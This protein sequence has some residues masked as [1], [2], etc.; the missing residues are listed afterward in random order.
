MKRRKREQEIASVVFNTD[1]YSVSRSRSNGIH[2]SFWLSLWIGDNSQTGIA[3]GPENRVKPW[4]KGKNGGE[5]QNERHTKYFSIMFQGSIKL[6][7]YSIWRWDTVGVFIM[8]I[9]IYENLPRIGNTLHDSLV[10]P[11]R[12]TGVLGRDDDRRG[13][14]ICRP[15]HIYHAQRNTHRQTEKRE[16]IYT[17]YADLRLSLCLCLLKL[18]VHD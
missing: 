3:Q 4:I 1:S 10:S 5:V 17:L 13:D 2:L 15:S 11:H 8:F 18:N 6:T 14:G 7:K 16:K 12:Y 9:F